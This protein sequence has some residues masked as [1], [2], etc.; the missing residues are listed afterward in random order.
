MYLC[1]CPSGILFFLMMLN[2]VNVHVDIMSHDRSINASGYLYYV[3]HNRDRDILVMLDDRGIVLRFPVE[4]DF[5]FLPLAFRSVSSPW[6]PM[7]FPPFTPM[8]CRCAPVFQD[9][10]IRWHPQ[11]EL[12]R[13]GVVR[14]SIVNATPNPQPGGPEFYVGVYLPRNTLRLPLLRRPVWLGWSC[15]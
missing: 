4:G 1:S 15:C 14:H 2:F 8:S 11:L 9:W 12:G 10:Q 5:S 6:L 13:N 7:F 3:C